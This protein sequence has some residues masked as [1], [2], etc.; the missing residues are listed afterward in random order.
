MS[1]ISER[2]WTLLGESDANPW[3]DGIQTQSPD[4]SILT[5]ESSKSMKNKKSKSARKDKTNKLVEKS[6]EQGISRYDEEDIN[7]SVRQGDD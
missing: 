2:M 4:L 6:S 7:M 3:C 1:I 5:V